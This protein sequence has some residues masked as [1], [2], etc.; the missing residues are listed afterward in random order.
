MDN[1]DVALPSKLRDTSFTFFDVADTVVVEDT[2]PIEPIVTKTVEQTAEELIS[3]VEPKVELEAPKANG[4]SLTLKSFQKTDKLIPEDVEIP[5]D[6]DGA[7]FKSILKE[8]LKKEVLSESAPD[9]TQREL[10]WEQYL[11]DK[12]YTEEQIAYSTAVALG[13]PEQTVNRVHQLRQLASAE[14]KEEK[15]MEYIVRTRFALE[16]NSK[17]LIDTHIQTELSDLEKLKAAALESQQVLQE[18]ADEEFEAEKAQAEA[19]KEA[20]RQRNLEQRKI[21]EATID[22]G[23]FGI[24]LSKEEAND[25]KKYIYSPDVVKDI[26]TPQGKKRVAYSQETW[27]LMEIEKDPKKRMFYSYLIKNGLEKAANTIHQKSSD[28]FLKKIETQAVNP[29]KKTVENNDDEYLSIL[30]KHII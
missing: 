3:T 10:E 1:N 29:V 22:E 11:H 21:F 27:D 25:L 7:T 9:I 28:D 18:M 24:K 23:F 14:L 5:D 4:F 26:D 20:Q 6:I 13:V 30:G 16:G 2:E 19:N 8:H 12:G 15:D 17:A